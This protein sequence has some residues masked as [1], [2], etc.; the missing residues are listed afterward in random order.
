MLCF[1]FLSWGRHPD[2]A[3]YYKAFLID[4]IMTRRW[5]HLGYL[6][7]MHMIVC[8]KGTTR[9]LPYGHFLSRVFK[10]ANIDLSRE[11]YFKTPSIYDTYDDQ[12]MGQMKFKKALDGSWIKKVERGQPQGQQQEPVHPEVGEE[13]EIRQMESG[14]DPKDG[15]ES[16]SSH[17]PRGSELDIPPLQTEIPS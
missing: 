2:E 13:A 10:D 16:Q 11:T 17:H 1:I 12:S 6:M 7:M 15:L 14:L 3:S 8:C 9:V 4:S 5:I